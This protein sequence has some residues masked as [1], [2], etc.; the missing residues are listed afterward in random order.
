[1]SLERWL[2]IIAGAVVAASVV[3]GLS[4]NTN[5]FWWTGFGGLTC[6]SQGSLIGAR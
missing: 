3:L 4:V 2:R 6:F 1:M 5:F